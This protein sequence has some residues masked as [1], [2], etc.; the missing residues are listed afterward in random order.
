MRAAAWATESCSGR[1]LRTTDASGGDAWTA[2][3]GSAGW[4]LHAPWPSRK[5][6]TSLSSSFLSISRAWVAR[7]TSTSWLWNSH[8]QRYLPGSTPRQSSQTFWSSRSTT[9]TAIVTALWASTTSPSTLWGRTR[10]RPWTTGSASGG[11]VAVRACPHGP[12]A[13]WSSPTS[14][15]R[16][17]RPARIRPMV[18]ARPTPRTPL[19]MLTVLRSG[20][21]GTSFWRGAWRP[22]T[23]CAN[24]SWTTSLRTSAMVIEKV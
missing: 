11:M 13:A 17:A 2:S 4:P 8:L 5:W 20:A 18:W 19:C 15:A 16:C 1:R 12:H 21:K 14:A 9:W 23:K 10:R 24:A 6:W 22:L 7:C 3:S